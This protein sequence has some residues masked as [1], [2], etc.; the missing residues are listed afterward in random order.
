MLASLLT[1]VKPSQALYDR[2]LRPTERVPAFA[3]S[4]LGDLSGGNI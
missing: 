4:V 3:T 2:F 1:F